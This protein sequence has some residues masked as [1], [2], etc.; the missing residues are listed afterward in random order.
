M[1]SW[2][3]TTVAVLVGLTGVTAQFTGLSSACQTAAA[4]F[5]LGDLGSCLSLT[6]LIPVLSE[7]GSIV[8]SLDSY[9]GTICT[10]SPCSNS[11][12]SSAEGTIQT[13]C[14]SDLSDKTTLVVALDTLL[15]NYPAIREAACLKSSSNN[16]YCVTQ[17]LSAVQNATGTPIT[18]SYL[19]GL[20]DGNS[21]EMTTLSSLSSDVLCTS[22]NQGIYQIALQANSSIANS[23]IGQAITSKCG[24]N[25][26]TGSTPSGV[27]QGSSSATSAVASSTS[28]SAAHAVVG[29]SMTQVV[30][31]AGGALGVLVGGWSVLL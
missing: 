21:T 19:S 9:F 30:A 18:F 10:S 27:T 25:F 23:T 6:S 15:Y 22:C 4:V 7:S 29:L 3:P 11:T 26:G 12:I 13:S 14:A 20:L 28:A 24:A 5:V 16:T 17:T 1:I 8:S 2:K 31:A